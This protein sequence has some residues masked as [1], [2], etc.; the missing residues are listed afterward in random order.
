VT[1]FRGPETRCPYCG[2]VN[3][4]V[5][6][7]DGEDT[8]PLAG[9]WSICFTCGSVGTFTGELFTVRRLTGA[10]EVAAARDD[11]VQHVLRAWR[12]IKWL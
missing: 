2:A 3:D 12:T 11:N 8:E 9:A 10:E 4:S 6:P 5:T 1:T 7:A